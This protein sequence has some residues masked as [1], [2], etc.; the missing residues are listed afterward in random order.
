V[1]VLVSLLFVLATAKIAEATTVTQIIIGSTGDGAFSY[2][3]LDLSDFN[4]G[5]NR[6]VPIIPVNLFHSFTF[7]SSVTGDLY[8][9]DDFVDTGAYYTPSFPVFTG[10]LVP[11]FSRFGI[12]EAATFQTVGIGKLE[13]FFD[14]VRESDN[15]TTV[16]ESHYVIGEQ[17]VSESPAFMLLG[18]GCLCLFG[19]RT[20]SASH[21]PE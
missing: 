4:F 19:L 3:T 8:T 1:T 16:G 6:T 20:F 11:R 17:Q 14:V 7:T 2:D 10:Q 13:L 15:G 9:F 12:F 18:T 5:V 21:K